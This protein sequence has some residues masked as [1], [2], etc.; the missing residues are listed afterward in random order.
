[1]SESML[2]HVGHIGGDKST[3]I[4]VPPTVPSVFHNSLPC[5][6]SSAVK[7][8]LPPISTIFEIPGL[9]DE[10]ILATL[11]VASEHSPKIIETSGPCNIPSSAE[12]IPE[13]SSKPIFILGVGLLIEQP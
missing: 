4:D 7:Y 8:R 11:P 6:P 10:P 1:M 2:R 5:I 12:P 3:T 13:P 9:E